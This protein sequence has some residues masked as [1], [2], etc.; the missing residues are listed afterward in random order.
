MKSTVTENKTNTE[1]SDNDEEETPEREENQL[2]DEDEQEKDEINILRMWLNEDL[3]MFVIN[4]A[5]MSV[6]FFRNFEE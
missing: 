5:L 3:P 1:E 2:W 4:N 6:Q